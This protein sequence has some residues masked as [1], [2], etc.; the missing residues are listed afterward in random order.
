[1]SRRGAVAPA[2][3]LQ[4]DRLVTV[5]AT[6]TRLT[7]RDAELLPRTAFHILRVLPPSSCR[8]RVMVL[9]VGV[10]AACSALAAAGVP[11]QTV[12]LPGREPEA[13]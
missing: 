9:A 1:M 5:Q 12:R 2:A 7:C 3:R 4:G 6:E 8:S 13:S 11:S 10:L